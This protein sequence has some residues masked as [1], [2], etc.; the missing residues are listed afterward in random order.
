MLHLAAPPAHGWGRPPGRVV[1]KTTCLGMAW[2]ASRLWH[3]A[4]LI[5]L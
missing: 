2:E 4:C 3:S 1:N 5:Y